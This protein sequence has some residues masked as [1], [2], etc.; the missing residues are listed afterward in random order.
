MKSKYFWRQVETGDANRI[1]FIRGGE[2]PFLYAGW[3]LLAMSGICVWMSFS[4]IPNIRYLIS[5]LHQAKEYRGAFLA[6][7]FS[8]LPLVGALYNFLWGFLMVFGRVI[9]IVDK[10]LGTIAKDCRVRSLSLYTQSYQTG[11]LLS[12]S[13]RRIGDVRRILLLSA[14]Y[15]HLKNETSHKL[16]LAPRKYQNEGRMMAQQ[17][18]DF[19]Q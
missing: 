5:E 14:L 19:L 3:I 9:I 16:L 12:I 10:T 7:F 1:E 4:F 6:Y 18:A 2:K 15:L 8:G 13:F 11:S 17:I